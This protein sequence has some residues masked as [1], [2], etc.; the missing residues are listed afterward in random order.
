MLLP[1]VFPLAWISASYITTGA[2]LSFLST[3]Q[4]GKIYWYGDARDYLAYLKAFF[5]SDPFATLFGPPALAFSLMRLRSSPQIRW[6]AALM[7]VPLL[8]FLAVHQGQVEPVGNYLRYLAPFLF[9]VYPVLAYAIKSA[10]DRLAHF[11]LARTGLLLAVVLLVS[12]TQTRA[13][14][15]FVNDPASEG[16]RVG[17]NIRAIRREQPDAGLARVLVERQYWQYLAIQV[18]ANDVSAIV[19]DRPLDLERR[20]AP[21]LFLMNPPALPGCLASLRIYYIIART[22]EVRQ[23]IERDLGLQPRETVNGYAFYPVPADLR[24]ADWSGAPC[25]L[26]G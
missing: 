13:A 22:A 21:S 17:E 18:G 23:V 14:F 15:R 8:A 9:V 6:L 2:P 19:Y 4:A 26:G 20:E 10:I 25:P 16:V 11:A 3:V 12:V 7:V 5:A 24:Q 1:W